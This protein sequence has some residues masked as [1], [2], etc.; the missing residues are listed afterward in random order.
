[1]EACEKDAEKETYTVTVGVDAHDDAHF[2]FVVSDNGGGM[3]RETR[4]RVFEEFYTTKGTGGTGLGL[5]VVDKIVNKHG[6]RIE[7]EAAPGEGCVFR[8]IL[9]Y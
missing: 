4:R 6:G 5:A 7:L 1:L 8:I 9:K 2:M 3:D